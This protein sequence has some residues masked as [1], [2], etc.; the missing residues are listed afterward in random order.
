MF[1]EFDLDGGGVIEA[2]ELMQIGKTRRNL[3][4]KTDTW[5]E[6][7]NS[8]L[9]ETIGAVQ[10]GKELSLTEE[11]YLVALSTSEVW[12]NCNRVVI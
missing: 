1:K 4:H 11:V 8:N 10:Q 7:K 12:P 2:N 3:G 5:T 9:M 6:E